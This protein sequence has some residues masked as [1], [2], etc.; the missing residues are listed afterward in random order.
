MGK[1]GEGVG[2]IMAPKKFCFS[3]VIAWL[4]SSSSQVERER[5]YIFSQGKFIFFIL[6]LCLEILSGMF[7]SQWP[8]A[9]FKLKKNPKKPSPFQMMYYELLTS[10][11]NFLLSRRMQQSLSSVIRGV[12]GIH[13]LW[14]NNLKCLKD[15]PLVSTGIIQTALDAA[16]TFCNTK[17]WLEANNWTRPVDFEWAWILMFQQT[18]KYDWWNNR[19]TLYRWSVFILL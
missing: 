11:E 8:L 18:G 9:V 19:L 14:P 3:L 17:R 6:I 4:Q 10:S 12:Q 13:Y 16:Q 15:L 7:L 1:N 5:V 2:L